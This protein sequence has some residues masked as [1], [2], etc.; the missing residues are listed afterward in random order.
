MSDRRTADE[1]YG[2]H[3][4]RDLH[5]LIRQRYGDDCKRTGKWD[6][7]DFMSPTHQIEVKNRRIL[8]LQYPTVMI[9]Y[10]KLR[11]AERTKDTMVTY[12]I[13]KF[14]NGTYEWKYDPKDY[15]VSEGGRCDRG[16]DERKDCGFID[17]RLLKK[18]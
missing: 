2:D 9:G 7:F 13:W 10:N 6:T 17:M 18:I 5:A 4:E 15:S 16:S 8:Y 12:F 14:L 11:Q 1:A 3:G